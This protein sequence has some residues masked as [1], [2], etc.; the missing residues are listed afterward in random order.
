MAALVTK[1][2]RLKE[3][4]EVKYVGFKMKANDFIVGYGLDYNQEGR[5][6]PNI[7]IVEE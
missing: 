2:E 1:P 4:V 3:K 5:N 6:L 7:Y